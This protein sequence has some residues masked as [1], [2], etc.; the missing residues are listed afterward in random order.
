[1]HQYKCKTI[2]ITK[3]KVDNSTVE[4][5]INLE[6]MNSRLC[7]TEEQMSDLEYKIMQITQSEQQTER[8]F[9]KKEIS[10]HDLCDNKMG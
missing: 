1:M 6:A 7:N 3:T 9:L 8:Q 5:K 4:I 2:K 10:M